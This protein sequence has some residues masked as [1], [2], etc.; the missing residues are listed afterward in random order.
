MAERP[1]GAKLPADP[2]GTR[3]GSR[4]PR[5]R[6][7]SGTRDFMQM[8][9]EV[10]DSQAPQEVRARLDLGPSVILTDQGRKKVD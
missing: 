10:P 9:P 8:P 4:G 2:A 1:Y 5:R 3:G 6:V 7:R